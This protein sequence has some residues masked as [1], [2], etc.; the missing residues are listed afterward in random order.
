MRRL[1]VLSAVFVAGVLSV[2]VGALQQSQAPRG[3]GVPQPTGPPSA[4]ALVVDKLDDT[5]FI[6]RG[7]NAGGN[8]AVFLTNEGVTVVDTK[9]PG[10]GQP[11]I[12]KIKTITNKPIV[13]VIN[14]HTHYDHVGGNVDF[15]ATVEFVSQSNTKKYMMGT[16]PIAGV[17]TGPQ[18]NQFKA[19]GG[20]GLPTRTFTKDL[21]IGKGA[22]EIDLHFFGCAHT[23]GDAFVVFP[24]LRTMHA[25]DVFPNKGLPIMDRNNGGC[26]IE[27]SETIMKAA[28]VKNIDRVITG[29]SDNTMTMAELREYGEFVRSFTDE[30]RAAKKAGKKMDEVAKSWKPSGKFASYGVGF[31]DMLPSN[32]QTVWNEAK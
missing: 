30:V 32:V 5:L 14:T 3:G 27:Y 9:I 21:T 18:E 16:E 29:H 2:S 24:A 17:Q 22:E 11:L 31:G 13:R 7:A 19:H 28:A 20:H 1:L 25:G 26:G 8:T 12:E 6:V 10:W 15:P 23:G 4:A